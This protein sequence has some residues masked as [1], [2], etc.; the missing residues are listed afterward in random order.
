MVGIRLMNVDMNPK[1]TVAR[2]KELIDTPDKWCQFWYESNGR[3]CF[4]MALNKVSS[5]SEYGH[6][7]ALLDSHLPHDFLPDDSRRGRIAGFNDSN[8]HEQ[9]MKWLDTVIGD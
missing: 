1:Q 5:Y 8:P 6:A 4:L 9:L 2:A 3:M 7:L